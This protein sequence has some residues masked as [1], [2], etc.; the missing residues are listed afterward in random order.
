[1]RRVCAA[2]GHLPAWPQ[3]AKHT[4]A[5]PAWA[6]GGWRGGDGGLDWGRGIFNGQRWEEMAASGRTTGREECNGA[7]ARVGIWPLGDSP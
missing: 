1:M 2:R 7:A 3:A 6:R 5:V 4:V